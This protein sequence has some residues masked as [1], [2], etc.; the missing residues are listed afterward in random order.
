MANHRD[1]RPLQI[2]LVVVCLR[3]WS[4]EMVRVVHPATV[5]MLPD[6]HLRQ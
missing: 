1:V 3:C 6:N 2:V 5:A 4:Q